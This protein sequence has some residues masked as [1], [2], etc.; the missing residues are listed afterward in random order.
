MPARVSVLSLGPLQATSKD[1]R[2]N[3]FEDLRRSYD[4]NKR[5]PNMKRFE[6]LLCPFGKAKEAQRINSFFFFFRPVFSSASKP[7]S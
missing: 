7:R 4:P 3:V 2:A 6:R 1:R 5:V